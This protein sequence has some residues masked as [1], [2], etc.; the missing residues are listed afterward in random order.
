MSLD[1]REVLTVLAAFDIDYAALALAQDPRSQSHDTRAQL[2]TREDDVMFDEPRA[3]SW[4]RKAL[5]LT[6]GTS[7]G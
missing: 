1:A 2:F 4:Q 7:N 6:H 5:P 3:R